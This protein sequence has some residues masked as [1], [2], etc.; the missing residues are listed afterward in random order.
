[1][2]VVY[3]AAVDDGPIY[4]DTCDVAVLKRR[5]DTLQQH[6]WG[7]VK[8][9]GTYQGDHRLARAVRA[10]VRDHRL[11]GE[12]FSAEAR[13]DAIAAAFARAPS[14]GIIWK[15]ARRRP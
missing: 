13:D 5:L 4:I 2:D 11:R 12:W 7:T 10:L 6:H 9:L 15:P 8:L 3:L 1:M 14:V